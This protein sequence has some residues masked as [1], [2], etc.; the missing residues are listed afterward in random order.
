[1]PDEEQNTTDQRAPKR[2]LWPLAV[3]FIAT[4]ITIL[5]SRYAFLPLEL[6]RTLASILAGCGGGLL[7][8][9]VFAVRQAVREKTRADPAAIIASMI[10][11]PV[12]VLLLFIHFSG[13]LTV[14]VDDIPLSELEVTGLRISIPDWAV[15]AE[16]QLPGNGSIELAAPA[17]E[18]RFFKLQ[19]TL[20]GALSR[21]EL[22][23]LFNTFGEVSIEGQYPFSAGRKRGETL[24]M[25]MEDGGKRIAVSYWECAESKLF[26]LIIAFLNLSEDEHLALQ[27]RIVATAV[28]TPID[29]SSLGNPELA[30]FSPPAGYLSADAPGVQAYVGPD[31]AV[32][33]FQPAE[34]TD[35][36]DEENRL[37]IFDQLIGIALEQTP[38]HTAPTAHPT[39]TPD[40]D[41]RSIF[42]Y[43][44]SGQY[45]EA[46]ILLTS[47]PCPDLG[48]QVVGMH[49]GA[50]TTAIEPIL[51]A[52]ST[53]AC[54]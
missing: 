10:L 42:E 19:W 16:M 12:P 37:L 4:A 54:P 50:T 27:E 8:S 20:D 18:G 25:E 24:Y 3:G 49:E 23:G 35:N 36:L 40:G 13:A 48:Y 28:C 53:A 1:M 44:V 22:I 43:S 26:V 9:G 38:T 15:A 2:W 41:T 29:A 52:L 39:R 11:P 33:L 47:W 21:D 14:D 45:G 51:Q 7:V 32:F 17:G 31:D 34:L 46:R 6:E 30:V 5:V